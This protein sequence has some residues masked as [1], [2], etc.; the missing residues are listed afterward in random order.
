MALEYLH[1][2]V[3]G[4]VQGLGTVEDKSLCTAVSKFYI[5]AVHVMSPAYQATILLYDRAM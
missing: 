1:M 2:V 3:A 4:W 5:V